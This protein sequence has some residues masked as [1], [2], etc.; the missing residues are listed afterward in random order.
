MSNENFSGPI[1]ISPKTG[2]ILSLGT[3]AILAAVVALS[4]KPKSNRIENNMGC[5]TCSKSQRHG[6]SIRG[7]QH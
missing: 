5:N 7:N 2:I 6:Y 1:Q 4:S 3:F